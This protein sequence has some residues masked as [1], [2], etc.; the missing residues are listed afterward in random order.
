VTRA[1]R[2]FSRADAQPVGQH[3]ARRAADLADRVLSQLIAHVVG[4]HGVAA[5]G[6]LGQRRQLR[7]IPWVQ[8][9]QI[10]LRDGVETGFDRR[11]RLAHVIRKQACSNHMSSHRHEHNV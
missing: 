8:L 10:Q 4:H 6:L 5:D 11:E 9:A 1:R 3:L 7:Q 2:R